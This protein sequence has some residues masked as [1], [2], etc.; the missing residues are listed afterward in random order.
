MGWCGMRGFVT[1]ATAFA[2]PDAFPHRDTVVLT[3][4]SVVLVTLVVQ[5]LTLAPMVRRLGLDRSEEARFELASAQ[6]ALARTALE[7]LAGE[8]GPE[9]ENLRY[10]LSLKLQR[11]VDGEKCGP[12]DRLHQLGLAVVQAER[13]ELENLRSE[14]KIGSNAYLGLQEQL[15]WNELT[16]LRDSERRIEEI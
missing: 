11:C 9:A 3:A 6:V 5:G 13:V 2:L 16:Q 10:R 7:S 8:Q 14:D 15:D 1:I 12:S 4:F